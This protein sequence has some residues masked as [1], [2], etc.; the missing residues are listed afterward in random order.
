MSFLDEIHIDLFSSRFQPDVSIISWKVRKRETMLRLRHSANR[1][2]KGAADSR[3]KSQRS[4]LWSNFQCLIIARS[5]RDDHL[6]GRKVIWAGRSIRLPHAIHRRKQLRSKGKN[7]IKRWKES[8]TSVTRTNGEANDS[9]R[10]I[11]LLI[12]Q[13]D[14]ARIDRSDAIGNE[15]WCHNMYQLIKLWH[16]LFVCWTK[17]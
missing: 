11:S 12:E 7:L 10:K 6:S 1:E 2:R 17:K 4:G 14:A 16:Q 15:L 5:D 9:S 13:I 3:S 8:S